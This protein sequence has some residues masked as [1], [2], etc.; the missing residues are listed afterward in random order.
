M[1]A[2]VFLPRLDELPG[3]CGSTTDCVVV[4]GPNMGDLAPELGQLLWQ[5]PSPWTPGLPR[6]CGSAT[7]CVDA[8][9]P[10]VGDLS[11]ELKQLLR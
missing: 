8:L 11:P 9:G 10:N 1:I 7:D 6:L 5:G 3:L 2:V 4:L